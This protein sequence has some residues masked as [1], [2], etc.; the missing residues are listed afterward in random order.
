VDVT[1]WGAVANSVAVSNGLVA[2]A[3]EA[4]ERQSPGRVV[5]FNLAGEPLGDVAVGALPDMLTFTPDGRTVVVANEG[6]PD[7]TYTVDPE[8]TVSLVDLS[9]GVAQATVV[10]V[11]FADFNLGGP[12]AGELPAGVRLFGP[13]A[14]VAQDLEPEYLAVSPDSTVAWV[15]LQENNAIAEVDLVTR[16]VRRITPLPL[17][18]HSLPGAGLDPSN[19]DG[20]IQIAPWPVYGMALPD[21]IAA[22]AVGSE[23]LLLTANE[24]DARDYQGYSEEERVADLQLDPTAYPDAATLQLAANLGRLKTTS[25]DGDLD[26]DGDVDQVHAYG[27]RSLSLWRG[28]DGQLLWDSGEA[29]EQRTADLVPA[30][31]NSEG[32]PD[33]FD[34]RSDDKGPEPESVVV[35]VVDGYRLA[36]VG[37]ERIGGVMAFDLSDP[38]APAFACY[39]PAAT[40]DVAPEGLAFVPARRSPSGEPLLLVVNEVSGTLSVYAVHADEAGPLACNPG[41]GVL[42]VGGD[43][44]AVRASWRSGAAS[45][46]GRPVPLTA[47]TGSFWFFDEENLELMVKVLDGCSVNGRHWVFAAGLTD[48]EVDLEVTDTWTGQ[49]RTY[50]SPL[51]TA[52]APIQDTAAFAACP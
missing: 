2:V 11:G 10:E 49:T 14:T 52:F 43:R 46:E 9:A 44:F 24:G 28:R 15:T 16:R 51:G 36:F 40:A 13:G 37:L 22:F 29:M 12:R 26:G 17:K 3:V 38:V 5:F 1:P 33:T 4:E 31:F 48:V 35:G 32:A 50:Q 23:V 27:T 19:Q 47:D 42:C 30:L 39:E 20:G 6:E 41:A 25:A 7:D 18:D 45:G 8:G 21:G 34:Q